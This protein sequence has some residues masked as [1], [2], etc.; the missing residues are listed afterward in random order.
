MKDKNEEQTV[1][2][3]DCLIDAA[4][5]S[6][7]TVS[8]PGGFVERTMNSIDSAPRQI[9]LSYLLSLR[10]VLY[11]EA[12]AVRVQLRAADMLVAALFALFWCVIAG[13]FVWTVHAVSSGSFDWARVLPAGQATQASAPLWLI[14]ICTALGGALALGM[15]LFY[16]YIE[17]RQR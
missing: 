3:M 5:K 15:L 14:P 17:Q 11:R 8:L 1:R 12:N 2:S 16:I 4:F 9:S 10:H 13:A 6:Y 7:P